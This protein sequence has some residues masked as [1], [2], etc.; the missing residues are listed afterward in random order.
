MIINKTSGESKTR[1]S[2]NRKRWLKVK[3][4][5]FKT[6]DRLQL[7]E[8]MDLEA[9][10]HISD[11][12]FDG[13]KQQLRISFNL[14]FQL[15]F[16]NEQ[17]VTRRMQWYLFIK[18]CCHIALQG[19]QQMEKVWNFG[20]HQIAKVDRT[21]LPSFLLWVQGCVSELEKRQYTVQITVFADR[22]ARVKPLLIFRGRVKW[23]SFR[24]KV[25]NYS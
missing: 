9:S 25:N 20:L 18:M 15:M 7:L 14:V 4:F 24:E 19:E 16:L 6:R 13:F 1:I 3:G 5:W 17:P 11:G 12:W 22:K 8:Q 21:P 10:F 23:I 2:F